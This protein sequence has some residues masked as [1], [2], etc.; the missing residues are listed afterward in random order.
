MSTT[1][2]FLFVSAF[3]FLAFDFFALVVSTI[4]GGGWM[5][6]LDLF[7]CDVD[8]IAFAVAVVDVNCAGCVF[9]SFPEG[10]ACPML[11]K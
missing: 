7:A 2:L 1:I 3:G 5:F 8:V 11:L 10:A 6:A 4:T 9:T